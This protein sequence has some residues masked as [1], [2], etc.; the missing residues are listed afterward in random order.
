MMNQA[1]VVSLLV[2]GQSVSALPAHSDLSGR[3]ATGVTPPPSSQPNYYCPR[4]D[5]HEVVDGP[6]WQTGNAAPSGA[7]TCPSPSYLCLPC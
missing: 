4:L 1:A 3:Q 5:Y 2:L 6:K 7:S